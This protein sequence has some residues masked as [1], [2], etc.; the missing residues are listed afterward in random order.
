MDIRLVM[1]TARSATFELNDGGIYE[2]KMTYHLFLDQKEQKTTK[3][4]I[5]SLFDLKPDTEYLLE[6]KNE[7]GQTAGSLYFRRKKSL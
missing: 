4:V 2:T 6:A 7:E 5:V 3:T 1:R